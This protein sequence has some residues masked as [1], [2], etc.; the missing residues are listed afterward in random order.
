MESSNKTGIFQAIGFKFIVY[1]L[2]DK[3]LTINV[4]TYTHVTHLIL[5]QPL[6]ISY[7]HHPILPASLPTEHALI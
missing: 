3:T 7:P 6:T 5:V 2:K 4:G 1:F